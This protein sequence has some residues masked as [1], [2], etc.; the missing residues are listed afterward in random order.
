ML[1]EYVL[2]VIDY[3]RFDLFGDREKE[4][5]SKKE[6]LDKFGRV[7]FVFVSSKFAAIFYLYLLITGLMYRHQT[8]YGRR[9]RRIGLLHADLA[10]LSAFSLPEM[11]T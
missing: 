1:N 8:C 2:Y 6:L 7:Y 5:W 3:I 11:H 4:E 9:I 10:A